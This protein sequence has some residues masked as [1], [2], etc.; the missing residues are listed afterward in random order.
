[1]IDNVL[2][3]KVFTVKLWNSVSTVITDAEIIQEF[4]ILLKTWAGKFYI[5]R[6]CIICTI[7]CMYSWRFVC[8]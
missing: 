1:M 7:A 6:N 8:I 2:I 5:R 3:M 4:K